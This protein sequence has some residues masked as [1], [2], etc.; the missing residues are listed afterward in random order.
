MEAVRGV[1]DRLHRAG[2]DGVL[3]G[4]TGLL[5][6]DREPG[7]VDQITR[8]AGGGPEVVLHRAGPDDGE[9][10]SAGVGHDGLVLG[11]GGVMEVQLELLA[12]D[13]TRGVAPLD[14]GLGRVE[15]L[16]VEAGAALEAGIGHGAHGDGVL[17]DPLHLL[18]SGVGDGAAV[19]VG[20]AHLG[21]VTEVTGA[22]SASCLDRGRRFAARSQPARLVHAPVARARGGEQRPDRGQREHE[23]LRPHGSVPLLQG[24]QG[25]AGTGASW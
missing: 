24:R 15:D 14:E 12:V 1:G 17:G 4:Q 25:T 22:P 6:G 20:A 8:R 2:L 11:D 9:V 16:L 3:A 18:G 5:R 10:L 7:D 13:A 21:Q 23:P 19:L